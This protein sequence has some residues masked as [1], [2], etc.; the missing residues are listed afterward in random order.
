MRWTSGTLR[1]NPSDAVKT[2]YL[3][4]P[5]GIPTQV[6][7]SQAPVGPAWTLDRARGLHPFRRACLSQEGGLAVL[8]QHR[9]GR[10]RG[11][12]RGCGR[13][14]S[15]VRRLGLRHRVAGRSRGRHPG[16][17]GQAGD[18]VVVRYEGPKG[19]P[20]HAGNAL[21]HELHQVQGPGQSL[22]P[23]DRWPLFGRHLGPVD[24]PRL[25]RGGRWRGHRSGAERRPHPHRHSPHASTCW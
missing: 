19:G 18:V 25:A 15:G 24:R 6:A 8:R 14:H 7:F 20:R 16:R 4:G 12:D 1:A 11:Q 9:A 3:A 21:P 17:Q 10:L 13:I 2:F 23:A 22:C 5:A